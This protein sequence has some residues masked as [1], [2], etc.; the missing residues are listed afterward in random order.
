MQ[1][2]T[3]A[4]HVP[5]QLQT[6]LMILVGNKWPIGDEGA[7]R[8]EAAAWR[9]AAEAT[10]SRS[11]QLLT[12]QRMIGTPFCRPLPSVVTRPRTAW[13][14]WPTKLRRSGL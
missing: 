9:Q 7:L 5:R 4:H 11:A 14:R 12:A 8:A 2:V 3:D 1:G 6:L 10:R 13:K